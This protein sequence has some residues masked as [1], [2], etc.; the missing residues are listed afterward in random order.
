[1]HARNVLI[2][3]MAVV[4][5]GGAMDGAFEVMGIAMP[6]GLNLGISV[7][8]SFMGFLWYRADSNGRGW[9]RSPWMNIAIILLAVVAIPYYLVRSRPAGQRLSAVMKFLGCLVLMLACMMAGVVAAALITPLL[10]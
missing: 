8:Y 2:V 10:A 5:I 7:L 6:P 9:V 4:F 3:G 1:M